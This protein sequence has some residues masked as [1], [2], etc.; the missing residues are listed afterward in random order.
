MVLDYMVNTDN[1]TGVPL[2]LLSCIPL[3]GLN[4]LC[5]LNFEHNRVTKELSIMPAYINR[6]NFQ[7]NR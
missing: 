5:Q 6:K 1:S 3:L 2:D 4:L 7:H